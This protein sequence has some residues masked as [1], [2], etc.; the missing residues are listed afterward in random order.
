[1]LSIEINL[2]LRELTNV[3]GC[4][5][6]DVHRFR[7]LDDLFEE[8]RLQRSGCLFS[9][10]RHRPSV[11]HPLPRVLPHFR[12]SKDSHHYYQFVER[13]FRIGHRFDFVRRR[14]R[15]HDA[16]PA[17]RYGRLRDCHFRQ[18]RTSRTGNLEDAEVDAQ[19]RAVINTYYSLAACCVTA[20]AVSALVSKEHKFNMVHIQNSTLAGGVAI[21]TAADMMINPFGAMI[22]GSIVETVSV[23]GYRYLT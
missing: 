22:V 8:V 18:Q 6:H 20:F 23:L 2:C 12:W 21:G 15:R 16:A 17:G 19:H 1:M 3:P 5:R 4:P 7:L 13:R 10:R 11:G 14:H 9:D